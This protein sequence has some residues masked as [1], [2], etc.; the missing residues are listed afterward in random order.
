MLDVHIYIADLIRAKD[1]DTV[2]LLVDTGFG[3]FM[4]A[5]FRLNDIDTGETTWRASNEAEKI[6]GREATERLVDLVESQEIPR[7]PITFLQKY[8]KLKGIDLPN[9]GLVVRSAKF[10]KY[11][12][13]VTMYPMSALQLDDITQCKSF[14]QIL[15]DEGF[16]KK[17]HYEMDVTEA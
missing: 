10:G 5:S 13:L 17:D 6:H 16:E 4:K 1:G 11:R 7:K 15:I 8:H 2:E 3:D 14:N 9:P 12:W